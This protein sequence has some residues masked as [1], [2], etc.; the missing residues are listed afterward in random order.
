MT[1]QQFAWAVGAEPKWIH[2]AARLLRRRFRRTAAEAQ[3]LRL[4][5]LLHRSYD[6]S[7]AGA[8]EI[9]TRALGTGRR[10]HGITRASLDGSARLAIDLD[11]FDS[12]FGA[13]FAA[14]LAFT[15][16]ERR[17]RPP[18]RRRGNPLS[19]ARAYGVDVDLL[20][21]SLALTPAERLDRLD[22]NASFLASARPGR[23]GAGRRIA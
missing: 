7:L 5:H 2:N 23:R 3:W 10:G 4:V 6:M 17:G 12:S 13:A 22:R 16:P 20:R 15:G 11:R 9:A 8:A 19:A 1:P 18:R 14:A 21:A